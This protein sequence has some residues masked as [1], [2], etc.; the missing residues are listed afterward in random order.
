MKIS[1]IVSVF[2]EKLNIA[3]LHNRLLEVLQKNYEIIFINDGSSDG[4]YEEIEK[5]CQINNKIIG[6]HFS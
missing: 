2:N 4:S 1:I 3:L 5:L 6:V